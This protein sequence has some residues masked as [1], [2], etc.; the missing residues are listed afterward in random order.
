[1]ERERVKRE[2]YLEDLRENLHL[3]KATLREINDMGPN[4]QA[5]N[6]L[7]EET[8]LLTQKLR[9]YYEEYQNINAVLLMEKQ[10]RL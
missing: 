3:N 7:L 4:L 2:H 5:I 8:E 10:M 9:N 6:K 1:L